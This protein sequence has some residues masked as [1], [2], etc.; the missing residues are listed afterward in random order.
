MSERH[1]AF[2]FE[3]GSDSVV[4]VAVHAGHDL[5]AEVEALVAVDAATRRREEDPYTDRLTAVAGT[6]AVS[7]RSRFEVDLNRPR[8]RAVYR[9]PQDAW[10]LEVWKQPLPPDVERRSL[11]IYDAFYAA[12]ADLLDRLQTRG[13]FVV[14]DLHSYNHRSEGPTAPPAPEA[15]NPEVNVGTGSLARDQWGRLVDRF[16]DDLAAAGVNGRRLDVRENVR[17][18]GGH[19]SQWVHQHYADRGCALAIEFKKTF[20]DEW[21]GDVDDDHLGQL[22]DALRSAVPGLVETAAGASR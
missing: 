8:D 1:R 22:A 13:P 21:T 5:R 9:Q 14:L 18:R 4:A 20:M 15:G 6:R 19:L 2:T 16:M 17:F 12:L 7:H 3:D 10:G 11:E